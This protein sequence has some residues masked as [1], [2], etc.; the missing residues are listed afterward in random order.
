M[1]D[2]ERRLRQLEQ[3]FQPERKPFHQI[4]REFTDSL[5]PEEERAYHDEVDRMVDAMSYEQITNTPIEEIERE[6]PNVAKLF[7][8]LDEDYYASS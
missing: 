5:T 2:K 3:T 4:F 6:Y 8:R 7:S 1:N